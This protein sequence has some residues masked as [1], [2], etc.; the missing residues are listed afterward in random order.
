MQ[1][2]LM[3]NKRYG[4]ETKI[5]NYKN[6]IMKSILDAESHVAGDMLDNPYD[7]ATS[8]EE[9]RLTAR[10]MLLM[11]FYINSDHLYSYLKK[12][13]VETIRSWITEEW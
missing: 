2:A 10:R 13:K 11:L 12:E 3:H 7:M 5:S 9:K 8:Y 4:N 1:Y 6:F